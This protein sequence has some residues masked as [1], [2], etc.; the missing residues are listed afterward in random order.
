MHLEGWKKNIIII[1]FILCFVLQAKAD[2]NFSVDTNDSLPPGFE[3]L[4]EPQDALIDIYYGHK[5]LLTQAAKIVKSQIHLS[6]AKAVLA[7]IPEIKNADVVLLKLNEPLDTNN[8]L[9]CQNIHQ[10]NCGIL[11]P[12]VIGGIYDDSNFKFNLFIN[13]DYLELHHVKKQKYLSPSDAKSSFIQQFNGVLSGFYGK[14]VKNTDYTFM[15]KSI[16]AYKENNFLIDYDVANND[17]SL[18]Q[19]ILEREFEGV[20]FQSGILNTQGFGFSFTRDHPILGFRVASSTNTHVDKDSI[21]KA[22]LQVFLPVRGQVDVIKNGKLIYSTYAEAGNQEID[23]A[24]FP[25]GT[26]SVTINVHNTDGQLINSQNRLYASSTNFVEFGSPMYFLEAGNV[27]STVNNSAL[28][29]INNYWI[30]RTGFNYRLT[31][32]ISGT[33]AVALSNENQIAELGIYKMGKNYE[34]FPSILT[35]FDGSF[36]IKLNTRLNYNKASLMFNYKKL[37]NKSNLKTTTN[38]DFAIATKVIDGFSILENSL[39]QADIS[40]NIPFYDG[41]ASYQYT[42]RKNTGFSFEKIQSLKYSKVLYQDNKFKLHSNYSYSQSQT[43]K[44]YQVGLSLTWSDRRSNHSLVTQGSRSIKKV[45][46]NDVVTNNDYQGNY[47]FLW[48]NGEKKY[49]LKTQLNVEKSKSVTNLRTYGTFVSTYGKLL[50]GLTLSKTNSLPYTANYNASFSTNLAISKNGVAFG[51]DHL[52]SSGLMIKIKGAPATNKFDVIVNGKSSGIASSARTTLVALPAFSIYDVKLESLDNGFFS[53]NQPINKIT[54][55]P[56][57]IVDLNYHINP[58][59]L[60]FGRILDLNNRP[61]SG[62]NVNGVDGLKYK[63]IDDGF[64]QVQIPY[65]T[66]QLS[67]EKNGKKCIKIINKNESFVIRM[68]NMKC[69]L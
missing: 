55:Y 60:V 68:G 25:S 4:D 64:V 53:F 63:T 14:D 15:G 44:L 31:T 36:G 1:G 52:D 33:A 62:V 22:P 35:N 3:N 58:M 67:F 10:K 18:N 43:D 28:P 61:V 40:F 38:N 50:S 66:H 56:G 65:D 9:V 42:A 41:L 2:V 54:L 39:T 8:Y 57:N 26:Y 12:E 23:T 24:T 30:S 47:N 13:T 48:N 21:H 5:Y 46:I 20:L 16:F 59:K 45:N 27:V 69:D 51:S 19:A 37:K 6:D 29:K 32:T 7:K 34:L 17:F 49:P 11:S